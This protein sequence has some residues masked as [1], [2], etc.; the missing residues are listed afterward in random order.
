[1]KTPEQGKSFSDFAEA[2]PIN[3]EEL[4]ATLEDY[5]QGPSRIEPRFVSD[6]ITRAE[7]DPSQIQRVR[8]ILEE[9]YQG[10]LSLEKGVTSGSLASDEWKQVID[11]L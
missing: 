1:M 9:G 3:Q 8:D 4:I 7:F 5:A 6:L 2:G 11:S 10:Q